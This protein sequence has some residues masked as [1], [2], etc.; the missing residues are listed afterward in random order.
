[1]GNYLLTFKNSTE[2]YVCNSLE[3]HCLERY[4]IS[5]RIGQKYRFEL[6]FQKPLFFDGARKNT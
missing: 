3:I 2:Y 6:W 4:E 1:M 5:E